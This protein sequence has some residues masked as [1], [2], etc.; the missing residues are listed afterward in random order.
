MIAILVGMFSC[1][2]ICVG[3]AS[4]VLIFMDI[5]AFSGLQAALYIVGGGG[6]IMLG[7]GMLR[8]SMERP[9]P[10]KWME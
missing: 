1:F 9:A 7:W 3:T 6:L 5:E 4:I 8:D 2:F 10:Y